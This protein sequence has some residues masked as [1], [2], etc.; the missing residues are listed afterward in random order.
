VSR[1]EG[2]WLFDRQAAVFIVSQW[3]EK[4]ISTVFLDELKVSTQKHPH[5]VS[6]QKARLLPA[7]PA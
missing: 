4:A 6:P 2:G 5:N 7:P 3:R 1:K